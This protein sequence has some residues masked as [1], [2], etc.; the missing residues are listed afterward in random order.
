MGIV[1]L[2]A[3]LALIAEVFKDGGRDANNVRRHFPAVIRLEG[4]GAV[5][6]DALGEKFTDLF[7]L[8]RLHDAAK[9]QHIVILPHCSQAVTCT[10]TPP[11]CLLEDVPHDSDVGGLDGSPDHACDVIGVVHEGSEQPHLGLAHE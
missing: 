2:C 10:G 8:V 1:G 11:T 3:D 7:Q 9:R 5:K 4:N 6:H